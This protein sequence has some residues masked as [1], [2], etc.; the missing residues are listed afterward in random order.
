MAD[1]GD[2]DGGG[3]FEIEE[4]AVIAATKS[5][6][7]ERRLECFYLAGTVSQEAIHAVENLQGGG[8]VN[9]A[10][11]DAGLGRPDDGDSRASGRSD[12]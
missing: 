6:A 5:E 12:S 11:I 7:G 2:V 3:V 1:G 4:D 8:A 10:V 9:G